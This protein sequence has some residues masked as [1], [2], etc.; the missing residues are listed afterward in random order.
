MGHYY[1]SEG[2]PHFDVTPKKAKEMGLFYSVTE[3]LRVLY[4]QG[5]ETW[6]INSA[7]DYCFNNPPN[8]EIDICDYKKEVKQEMYDDTALSLGTSIHD[9][10]ERILRGQ[11]ELEDV[12]KKLQKFVVP[13]IEYFRGKKFKLHDIE[14]IV[15]NSDEGY[16]GTADI[17]AET[18]DG[19]P[20][21]MD[22]KSTGT[23]PSKPYFSQ[24]LQI[25]AYA[26]ATFGLDR[27]MNHEVWGANAY[28][29]TSQVWKRGAEKGKAKFKVMSY[30]PEVLAESYKSFQMVCALWREIEG[31]DPRVKDNN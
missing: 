5:L 17:V 16:A 14:A 24:K 2:V 19:D 10:I 31:Y 23:I 29:S 27:V 26:V 1:S 25:S 21:I 8:G 7:I 9:N 15:T 12:D 6:K 11:L 20:F 18:A 4:S 22:W 28:I 3:I 13:C 30:E